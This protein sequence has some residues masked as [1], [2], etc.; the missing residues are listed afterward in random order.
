MSIFGVSCLCV[1][2]YIYVYRSCDE[3]TNRRQMVVEMVVVLILF[4]D[5]EYVN[6]VE[7]SL[8]H[9]A[10]WY[11][12]KFCIK[13]RMHAVRIIQKHLIFI[14]TEVLYGSASNVYVCSKIVLI[15]QQHQSSVVPGTTRK[16]LK[17]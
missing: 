11:M 17:Y 10:V 15:S 13:I 6:A 3:K 14:H 4:N 12:V 7:R 5:I 8:R 1:F 16:W 9:A 2:L